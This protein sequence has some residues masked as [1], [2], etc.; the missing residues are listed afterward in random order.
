MVKG[1][2]EWDEAKRAA[3][4]A[5]HRVDFITAAEVFAD[6]DHLERLDVRREYGEARW[7]CI[8]MAQGEVPFVAH[9]TR[10]DARRVIS[11][12]RASRHERG[13]Y[14]ASRHRSER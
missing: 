12:R 1:K 9:A 14:Y 4:L 3:N 8:G 10:G 11:V 7:H 6:G 13:A 2:V 5:K